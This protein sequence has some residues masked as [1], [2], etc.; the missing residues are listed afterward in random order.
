MAMPAMSP[1]TRPGLK[2]SPDAGGLARSAA[3]L[4]EV[5]VTAALLLEVV[6]MM[7]GATAKIVPMVTPV[8]AVIAA[9]IEVSDAEPGLRAVTT[10]LGLIEKGKLMV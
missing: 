9:A 5:V 8:V 1:K 3:V 2:E 10:A 7:V 6:V 4:W